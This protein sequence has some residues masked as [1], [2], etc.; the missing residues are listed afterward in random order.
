[1]RISSQMAV[2]T[3]LLMALL[4]SIISYHLYLVRQLVAVSGNLQVVH[5]AVANVARTLGE[6]IAEIG[7]NREKLRAVQGLTI[8]VP[9]KPDGTPAQ[10]IEERQEDALI[11]HILELRHEVDQSQVALLRMDL[12]EGEAEA[13]HRL[14]DVWLDVVPIIEGELGALRTEDVLPADDGRFVTWRLDELTRGAEALAAANEGAIARR[15]AQAS[16]ARRRAERSMWIGGIVA[17]LVGIVLV[18]LTMGAIRRPLAGLVAATRDVGAGEFSVQVDPAPDDELGQL[19]RA[20]NVMVRRLDE[21]ERLK[22]E[23]LAHLSHELKTPLATMQEIHRL[24]L[25]RIPGPLTDKQARFLTLNVESGERLATMI[26]NLL[27]VS[28]IEAGMLELDRRLVDLRALVAS[29]V[30]SFGPRA[31]SRGSKITFQAPD[32]PI[33]SPIDRDRVIQVLDNLLDNALAHPPPGTAVEVSLRRQP[34]I[35]NALPANVIDGLRGLGVPAT[36]LL[37]VR[38]HGPGIPL[39]DR[40]WVFDRFHQVRGPGSRRGVGLGLAIAREISEAH[41]GGIWIEDTGT[42]GCRFVVALPAEAEAPLRD[43]RPETALPA[44]TLATSGG[45]A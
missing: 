30:E 35:P 31:Q 18:R 11:Q 20:F 2:G 19:G 4:V 17:F 1:M 36:A 40:E 28:R 41:G 5:F 25:D 37:T 43:E 15:L 45:G 38:D 33:E 24:L 7:K 3:A 6:Q 22:R 16:R 23:F 26:S 34:G 27:D 13:A 29:R 12:E 42:N 21:I 44:P 8:L 32:G 9:E 39:E 10:T 14:R